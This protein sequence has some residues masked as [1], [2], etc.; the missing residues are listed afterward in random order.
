V[1]DNH[2]GE[3]LPT[4]ENRQKLVRSFVAGKRTSSSA[5]VPM[6]IIRIIATRA[7]WS[8]TRLTW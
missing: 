5:I 1:L 8:K 3:L 7:C 4:I 6:I 2:D